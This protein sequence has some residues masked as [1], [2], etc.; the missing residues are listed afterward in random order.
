[1]RTLL[2]V[3][4]ALMV[5]SSQVQAEDM[6]KYLSDTQEMVRQGRYKEAL[7]RYIWFHNHALEHAPAMY[8]VRLS[9]ALGFWKTLGDVYPAAKKALIETRDRKT[10]QIEKGEGNA[11]LF[12]DVSSLNETLEEGSKTIELFEYL[13]K[14]NPKL[15]K[16]CWNVAKNE[17]ISTKRFDLVR[18]YL[19]NPVREFSRVKAMYD[20]NTTLYNN[21]QIGGAEFKAYNEDHFVEESLRL[22]EVAVALGD[23]RAVK[24][25]QKKALAVV[26][27]Y[28]LRDT[29]T[30]EKKKD[31][32]QKN[33]PDKK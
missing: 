2:V 3:I 25:I 6:Q 11:S 23:E 32:Q 10:H 31:A 17:V 7:E 26:D 33:P 14:E 18:K 9:F 29:I 30:T 13:D 27:D 12:H 1:M 20:Y 5:L 16:Q 21:P 28:R 22:I 19:G 15:A 24:E 8:G 4:V